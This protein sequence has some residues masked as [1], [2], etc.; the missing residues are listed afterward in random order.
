R[1][2]EA[3]EAYK[4]AH[5]ASVKDCPKCKTTVEKIDGCNHM[6]CGGCH[7]HL[8]WVCLKTFEEAED[9]YDHMTEEHGGIGM[10]EDDSG[11]SDDSDEEEDEGGGDNDNDDD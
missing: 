4:R 11:D 6:Q 8:C 3:F 1:A 9:C 7:V 2:F 10:D 5:R